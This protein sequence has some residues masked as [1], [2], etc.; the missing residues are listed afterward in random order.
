M[1]T[2]SFCLVSS[3]GQW[4][5]HYCWTTRFYRLHIGDQR[6][7]FFFENVAV[8]FANNLRDDSPIS[9]YRDIRDNEHLIAD[10]LDYASGLDT[11]N[12]LKMRPRILAGVFD[13][14]CLTFDQIVAK[15]A[16]RCDIPQVV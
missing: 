14:Q 12:Y 9:F 10:L 4:E 1:K 8:L 11:E 16:P 13:H 7:A 15:Y 5:I 2:D 3:P 6:Y